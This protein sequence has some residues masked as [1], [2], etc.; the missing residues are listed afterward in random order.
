VLNAVL[1][2]VAVVAALVVVLG[3]DLRTMRT[4]A[5]FVPA[6]VAVGA[7]ALAQQRRRGPLQYA[8]LMLLSL[9]AVYLGWADMEPVH[10]GY[11]WLARAIRLLIVLGGL[12]FAYG[13]VVHRYALRW[14][15]WRNSARNV[16]ATLAVAAV[17]VLALVLCMEVAL[18]EPGVGAPVERVQA[19]VVAVA[20][21]GM[22]VGLIVMAVTERGPKDVSERLKQAY[23]YG[24]ELVAALLFGH[25]YLTAPELFD[26]HLRLYWPYIVLVIAFAGV[27]AGE[28]LRRSGV[29]VMG[30]P[31]QQTGAFL[32]LLP[33]I[34]FWVTSSN[35]EY[36]LILFG[37][38][39]LYAM[40]SICRKS[41]AGALIA[42][43][44]G[45]GA[46]WS[47]LNDTSLSFRDHPQFWL[48]PP[49]LS[50]LV[51]AELNRKQLTEAQLS[52]IRYM[53][54]LLIYISSTAEIF[55]RGVADSLWPPMILALL[56]VGG[57]LAGIVMR[58][59][60]FL[61]LGASFVFLSVL[62][63]VWHAYEQTQHVAVWWAF[64][65]SL[66]LFILTVFGVFEKKRAEI[67]GLMDHMRS[68][69][70]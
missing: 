67:H 5:A 3:F 61:Y 14:P 55:V 22:T 43:L 46:L 39:I 68:W 50:V 8:A 34:G 49:A 56:A 54:V 69:D 33:V 47:V 19:I 53:S 42:A 20:L 45:N 7:A 35:T 52:G 10:Q 15:D 31:L 36:S 37:V 51:A 12:V 29:R 48:I 65:I 28:L 4:S 41:V 27:G 70:Q 11:V 64:G 44:A 59:R 30:D 60:A 18:F 16:S 63:M 57:A 40:F 21:L 24:A 26:T 32:P 9:S 17:G 23:V 38:G 2:A 13:V 58:V 66:G 1:G 62:T 25:V 6:L